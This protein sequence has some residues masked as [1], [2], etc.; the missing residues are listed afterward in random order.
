MSDTPPPVPAAAQA[1]PTLMSD[2][3]FEALEEILTSEVVPEDCMDLEMLDGYLAAV[4]IAPRPIPPERWMPGVW[5]AHGEEADFGSGSGL[6]RAIRL[7]KAYHNELLATLGLDDE[8]EA[9]WEPFCF[10]ITEGDSLKLG[11]AWVDGFTQGLDL[12][13][14]DWAAG[15]DEEV[16]EAVRETLDEVLEPWA[17]EDAAGAD[18]E[19]RLG[20]LVALGEAVN[21]IHAHWRDLD[22]A[23]PAP[24]S[25]EAPR[26]PAPAGPGRN[27]PCPCGSG[28]KFK[29]CCGAD[30]SSADA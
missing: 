29:K 12:W 21:D 11:E 10:A 19:T 6:Q 30:S 8:D 14:D 27:D 25:V 18:D 2:E 13:P 20:W 24:L 9:C 16:V 22:F 23:P 1:I 17:A 4:L 7:V 28:K 3:D 15:L 26:R 5:S